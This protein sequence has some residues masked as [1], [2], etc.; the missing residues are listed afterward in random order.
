MTTPKQLIS[1]ASKILNDDKPGYENTS[2]SVECLL[3]FLNEGLCQ[4][5]AYRPTEFVECIELCLVPGAKQ[6]LPPGVSELVTIEGTE[7]PEVDDGASDDPA[8]TMSSGDMVKA[9]RGK[10]TCVSSTDDNC[11]PYIVAG[12]RNAKG[13][14]DLFFVEPPVPFGEA[15]VVSAQVVKMPVPLTA[16]DLDSAVQ[17]E[18]KFDPALVDWILYRAFSMDT[19]SQYAYQVSRRHQSAFYDAVNG[20]YLADSRMRSGYILGQEGTG[21]E[22]TG[23]RNEGRQIGR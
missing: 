9:L 4:L 8:P 10:K 14:S 21:V 3:D 16:C 19:E 7:D 2:W 1:R 15:P 11:G 12:Y 23:W 6:Q 5:A 22:R 17:T 18:C 20:G 13:A